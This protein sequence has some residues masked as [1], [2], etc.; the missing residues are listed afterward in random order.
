MRPLATILNFDHVYQMQPK[1]K[2]GRF[3]W[4]DLSDVRHTNCYC[5]SE[6]LA[7]IQKRLRSRKAKAIALSGSGNYHYV[8]YLFL[9]DVEMPFTLV[10]FDH[11]TDMLPSPC[12]S[13]IS[14][15]SWVT[16]SIEECP[17]L[18]HVVIIGARSDLA[19]IV[20]AEYSSRV[21]VFQEGTL[22]WVEPSTKHA[23][24]SAIP[25]RN[26]YVS[27]DKD[28]LDEDDAITNWD[29]GDMRLEE[30]LDLLSFIARHKDICGLDLCGEYPLSVTPNLSRCMQV[31]RINEKTNR[32]IFAALLGMRQ[33]GAIPQ[34]S[35]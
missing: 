26:V 28:V 35:A 17:L 3:D 29:Q 2:R 18:K 11:H 9:S 20:P 14:C 21:S 25:T 34:I 24:L 10:L 1:L 19:G 6:A 22:G 5:E 30:L 13:V 12:D 33:E 32:R 16:T 8:T 23:I 27:I 7:I 4:I 15:G 31:A